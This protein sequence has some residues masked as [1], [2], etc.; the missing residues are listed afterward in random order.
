MDFS[1]KIF[2]KILCISCAQLFKIETS[3]HFIQHLNPRPR[4]NHWI[5]L[6]INAIQNQ[7]LI[8]EFNQSHIADALVINIDHLVAGFDF[9]MALLHGINDASLGKDRFHGVVRHLKSIHALNVLQ[10]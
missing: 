5:T 6:E 10:H 7:V 2:F 3:H 9:S 1:L 4:L 8:C